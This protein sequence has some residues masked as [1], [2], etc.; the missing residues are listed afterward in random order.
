MHAALA[1]PVLTDDTGTITVSGATHV[2]LEDANDGSGDPITAQTLVSGGSITMYAIARDAGGGFEGNVAANSWTFS[3]KTGGVLDGD[4]VVAVDKKSAKF[5]GNKVGTARITASVTG[6]GSNTTGTI[7]VIAGAADHLVIEDKADGTGNALGTKSVA[8]GSN[9]TVYAIARDA[10]SNFVENYPAGA[11]S[12]G[13]KTGGIVDGDLVPLNANKSARLEG[14]VAGT[15][16]I[17]ATGL[18][19]YTTGTITVTAGPATQVAV[20]DAP[21][22]LGATIPAQPVTA[23]DSLTVFVITRDAYNNFVGNP[24]ATWSLTS[25]TGGVVNG[26]LSVAGNSKS[27]TFN[28]RLVG[29]CKITAS[30]GGVGSDST[31]TLTVIAGLASG[32]A[33][34]P[35]IQTTQVL[36]GGV[37]SVPLIVVVTDEFGNPVSG[38]GVTLRFTPTEPAG[39]SAD[40]LGTTG[41][42]GSYT[43]MT[44]AASWGNYEIFGFITATPSASTTEITRYWAVEEALISVSGSDLTIPAGDTT[45]TGQTFKVYANTPNGTQ[46]YSGPAVYNNATG[47]TVTLT[48]GGITLTKVW[49]K[50]SGD[51]AMTDGQYNWLYKTLP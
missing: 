44:G 9:F 51:P 30:V 4:L 46:V 29:T 38:E 50:F 42:D 43:F 41:S 25:K 34:A 27:A 20:V 37:D 1:S 49:I 6:L 32:I 13:S 45:T 10:A 21:T 2:V 5:T 33:W 39:P 28:G 14:R 17:S 36:A 23:G 47:N 19:G 24:A 8:S 7:T 22:N 18:G 31:G 40:L 12:L 11:W 3:T 35:G 15:A 48:L 26:D 16:T